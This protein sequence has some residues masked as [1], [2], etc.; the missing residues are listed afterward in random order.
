MLYHHTYKYIVPNIY[1]TDR[2]G[3]EKSVVID[4]KVVRSRTS[5]HVFP[6]FDS[7]HSLI[8]QI[9]SMVASIPTSSFSLHRH[10]LDSHPFQ[11]G[12]LK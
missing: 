3:E 9:Q 8:H 10:H 11:L 2:K 6:A 7:P 5:Q 1:L 4:K 12:P